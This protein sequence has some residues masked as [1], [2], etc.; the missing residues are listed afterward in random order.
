MA[1]SELFKQL[2]AQQGVFS[3]PAETSYGAA[4]TGIASALPG[5]VDPYGSTGGN[6]ARVL[7]GSLLAGLLGYQAKK[8]AEEENKAI[9][10]EL[11]ALMGA[12]SQ[13]EIGNVL[14]QS[15]YADRL[16]PLA[17][18]LYGQLG[19]AEQK[20]LINRKKAEMDVQKQIAISKGVPFEQAF[21]PTSDAYLAGPGMKAETPPEEENIYQK[22]YDEFF[23]HATKNLR[24]SPSEANKYVKKQMQGEDIAIEDVSKEI[25]EARVKSD[26]AKEML[27]NARVGVEGAGE[28]GGPFPIKAARE[29]AS[30]FYARVPTAGGMEEAKQRAAQKVLDS[31]APKGVQALRS[32]GAVSNKETE[33]I[34]K[35]LPSS[36]NTPT[37]NK[38]LIEQ[39]QIVADLNGEYIGA[40]EEYL[41][42][43]R[44]SEILPLWKQY[45]DTHA[46]KGYKYNYDRMSFAEWDKMRKSPGSKLQIM[47]DQELEE[48]SKMSDEELE[49]ALAL[50]RKTR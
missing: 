1:T 25:K 7:G 45:K 50:T 33:M 3:K 42:K 40:L 11:T 47:P 14:Q 49:A 27:F 43:G 41:L 29:I 48:I 18:S 31:I 16:S 28:T 8:Q 17:M 5:V 39:M 4:A 37:E 24:M 32:P 44:A 21:S 19:T 30:T 15:K 10:P 26:S 13:E 9:L 12:S 46:F 22:K 6:L 20:E 2:M 36:L 23:A 34:I 38:A 35:T